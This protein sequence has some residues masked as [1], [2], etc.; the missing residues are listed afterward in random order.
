MDEEIWNKL[1]MIVEVMKVMA[2]QMTYLQTENITM[3]DAYGAWLEV[4]GRLKKMTKCPLAVILLEKIIFRMA[5]KNIVENDVM[6]AALFMDPRFKNLLTTVQKQKAESHLVYLH[7][8]QNLKRGR[9]VI[10]E[11]LTEDFQTS[12]DNI[13]DNVLEQILRE[14]EISLQDMNVNQLESSCDTLLAEI[15]KFKVIGR[16][17]AGKSVIT[18]WESMKFKFPRMYEL[19]KTVLEVSVERNFSTLDFVLN[20]RRTRLTDCNLEMLLLI[21]L[22][23][24]MF[25]EV[26][27]SGEHQFE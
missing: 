17:H 5:D 10:P 3:S 8:K 26:L 18:F 12:E 22:N 14:R 13:S 1:P 4:E 7:Q 16:I 20:K 9:D 11:I 21:K 24:N 27:G 2:D 23:K 15:E 25:Y 6:R 19:A